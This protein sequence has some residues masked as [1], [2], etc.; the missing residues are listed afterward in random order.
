VS[1]GRN[2]YHR[3]RARET[4]R[5]ASR[6]RPCPVCGGDHKCS[7]GSGGFLLCGRRTGAVAGFVF[8]GR[9]TD[10]VWGEYRRADDPAFQ[11]SEPRP[12][13]GS[14]TTI[15]WAGVHAA[16]RAAFPGMRGALEEALGVPG[17]A[18]DAV[19]YGWSD[20]DQ[21]FTSPERDG[22]GKIVGIN[23]RYRDGSKKHMLGGAR[24]L[25][26]PDGFPAAVGPLLL[27][28][29][30]SDTA[31]LYGAGVVGVGRPSNTGGVDALKVL[32]REFSSDARSFSSARTTR[33][34][35]A[36]IGR[37]SW[38]HRPGRSVL[39][40]GSAARF[41]GRRCPTTRRTSGSGSPGMGR[42]GPI[43][44]RSCWPVRRS[45]SRGQT[46]TRNRK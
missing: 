5:E 13:F 36:G 18:L 22:A 27:V 38:V 17:E 12:V 23:R 1:G 26:I 15:D 2:G 19:G 29:G 30:P 14:T 25:T 35:R 24:G 9:T 3:T 40:T 11:S 46:L 28:E 21:A 34:C 41:R 42:P 4:F 31:A 8:L 45:C 7:V 39:R 37:A 10:G 16:C 33:R 44:S 20:A 32:L 43:W 6:A